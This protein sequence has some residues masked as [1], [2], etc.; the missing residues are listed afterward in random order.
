MANIFVRKDKRFIGDTYKKAVFRGFTDP[1][2]THKL[3]RTGSDLHLDLLGP[4]LHAEV[5]DVIEVVF[6]NLASRPFSMHPHG[7]FYDI[8]S[9]GTGYNPDSFLES[10]SG[11]QVK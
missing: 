11:I 5:G 6:K 9:S 1:T 10:S 7:L 3:S 4:V 2:F 8:A